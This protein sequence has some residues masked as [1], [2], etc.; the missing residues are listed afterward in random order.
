M[1]TAARAD[2]AFA[3]ARLQARHGAMPD[4][5]A[6]RA[7]EASRTAPHYFA[8]A[9]KGPL[10]RWVEGIAEDADAHRI[11]HAL[12][13]RWR[14]YVDEVARWQAPAWREATRWFGAL[15]ELPLAAG[16]LRGDARALA[17]WPELSADADAAAR[18]EALRSSG[19]AAFAALPADA[20]ARALST[21]W[22]AEWNRRLPAGAQAVSELRAPAE[23]LLPRLRDDA[24]GRSTAGEPT[25]RAL[26]KLFRRHAFS[27]VAAFAH[28]ALVALDVERLR[29]GMTARRLASTATGGAD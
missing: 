20:D 14:R 28:L 26:V 21:A 12:R 16:L 24:G 6:W 4:A 3:Q 5:Q 25:R 8:L 17:A 11:E 29:G 22:L 15:V 23:L 2:Y 7:L 10:A 18:I 13:V 27:P 19:L 1:R 9:R